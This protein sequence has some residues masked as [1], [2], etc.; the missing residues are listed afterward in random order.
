[1]ANRNTSKPYFQP[2]LQEIAKVLTLVPSGGIYLMDK[3]KR[4]EELLP[5]CLMP[6][7]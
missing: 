6:S 3:E 2:L 4:M 7:D 5:P 1:M